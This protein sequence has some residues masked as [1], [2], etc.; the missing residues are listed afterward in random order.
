MPFTYPPSPRQDQVDIYHGMEVANPYRWLEDSVSEAT[1]QWIRAQNQVTFAYLEQLPHRQAIQ[2]RLTQLWNY[3]RYGIPFRQG[4][5]YFY[6]KNDGLQNQSVL[7]TLASLEAEPRVLLDPNTLSPDGT[8]ALS[9]LAVSEDGAWLAYGLSTAGSDWVEWH[10]RDINTGGDTG[11]ELRWVKFSSVAW[12]HDHQGFFYSR[13]DEPDPGAPAEMVNYYQKLYYHRL[14]TPKP[15]MCWSMN[16]LTK[17]SGA[18]L[19][20]SPRMVV[21]W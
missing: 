21:I 5:R 20:A 19:A 8:V 3:E 13:Y 1:R 7:Y 6:F 17:R 11:D 12:T 2:Q 4:G 18:S 10:V 14:G 15:P 9:G 16:V